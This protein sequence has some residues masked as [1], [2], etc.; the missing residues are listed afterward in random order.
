MRNFALF[1]FVAFVLFAA[2]FAAA[3]TYEERKNASQE[4]AKTFSPAA[5]PLKNHPFTFVLVG[6]NNGA[7]V[8]KTLSSIFSQNY[9][10]YR[11]IYIDD[12]SDNGSFE[13]AKE[14]IYASDFL[15][16]TILVHNE[17]RLGRLA[18]IVRAVQVCSDEEI[19]VLLSGE[20]WLAHEW[21]LQRL[22]A[23]YA[24]PHLWMSFAQSIDF[25]TYSTVGPHLKSF[26]VAL[27]KKIKEAD[28]SSSIITP[29]IEMA[30]DHFASIPEVLSIHNQVT[31]C[32]D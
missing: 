9:E 1:L 10:N 13:L 31:A 5:Y 21:V 25:P 22:N 8:E 6:Y 14:C 16:K 19:I 11:L 3:R 24:D 2:S 17:E 27:F 20:D 4:L 32:G 7:T 28:L 26:Y 15:D 30:K 12:A 18:N 23:Y 29:M